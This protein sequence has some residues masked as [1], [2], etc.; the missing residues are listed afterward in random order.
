MTA[1]ASP[2][3]RLGDAERRLLRAAPAPRHADAMK[4]VLTDARFDDDAWIFERKLDGVRCVAVRDG[5]PVTLL[6]RNDLSL[7]G[8][9]PEIAAALEAQPQRRFVVDGEVVAFDGAQTS[10]AKLARRGREPVPVFYYIF[11]VLWLDGC[12]VRAL[13]LRT[14]KRL[15]RD[16]LRFDH[17]ELRFSTHRNGDGEAYFEEACRK[18]WEGLIAKRADSP[19]TSKRSKDWLKFKCQQG[20]ELVI[21]GFTAPKGSRTDFGALL[22]GYYDDGALRYAGKV[23]TGFDEPTLASLGARLRELRQ[24]DPPFADPG[25]IHEPTATWVRPELVA[26]LGFSEW[27]G[28]G[29][30]R[31]PRF[32]G[33]RD[34][35]PPREVVREAPR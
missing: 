12:D 30:L 21:G 6:S 10:F 31:H 9:Y 25:Q 20:Q 1:A 13:P 28:A 7:N 4:A 18:G 8:R 3:D 26:Q 19:Y 5:G 22:L 27:T 33:L 17:K 23:G 16:E 11:D 15:L 2:F 34:D 35:K 29:R 32:L 14:R 24:A